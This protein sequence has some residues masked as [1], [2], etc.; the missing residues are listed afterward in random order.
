M[1]LLCN[2]FVVLITWFTSL[3]IFAAPFFQRYKRYQL[4]EIISDPWTFCDINITSPKFTEPVFQNT[5]PTNMNQG[6]LSG[7]VTS[8]VLKVKWIRLCSVK[9]TRILYK[10]TI[11]IYF[12]LFKSNSRDKVIIWVAVTGEFAT[13]QLLAT[14]I[15]I[16]ITSVW[17]VKNTCT[18]AHSPDCSLKGSRLF[19]EN[20]CHG[21]N[22]TTKNI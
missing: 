22:K 3:N 5:W 15:F 9:D 20:V 2:K 11:Y 19:Y 21:T 12:F 14:S 6:A 10:A 17:A 16:R 18:A 7:C 1:F 4:N 8:Q 13:Q